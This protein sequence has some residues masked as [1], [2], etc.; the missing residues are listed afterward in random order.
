MN[1]CMM[2]VLDTS[3]VFWSGFEYYKITIKSMNES[4]Y[5]GVFFLTIKLKLSKLTSQLNAFSKKESDRMIRQEQASTG[6]LICV[7]WRSL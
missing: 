1:K 5:Y 3:T 2:Q 4:K 6:T 7:S